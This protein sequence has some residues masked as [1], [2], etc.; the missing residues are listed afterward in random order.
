[1]KFILYA[2]AT[3]RISNI[4]VKEEGP[5]ELASKLREYTGIET[6]SVG[7]VLS[8]PPWNPLSCVLCTSVWVAALLRWCPSV[9]GIFA[10]S[11]VAVLLEKLLDGYSQD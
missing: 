4:L 7:V 6:N 3:W 8:Y 5:F 9:H 11:G 2:L 10:A 1:M